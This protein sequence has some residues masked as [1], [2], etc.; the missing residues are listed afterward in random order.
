M[1]KKPDLIDDQYKGKDSVISDVGC[2]LEPA[3]AGS[4]RKISDEKGRISI[5]LLDGCL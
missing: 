5:Y 1:F 4:G 2:S 3:K